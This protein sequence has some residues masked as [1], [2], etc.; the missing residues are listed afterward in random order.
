MS[1]ALMAA[2]VHVFRH[3]FITLFRHSHD[4]AV[5]PADIRVL[6]VLGPAQ[7]V[8]DADQGTV[9]LARDVV[10][11]LQRWS[12]SVKSCMGGGMGMGIVGGQ[13]QHRRQVSMTVRPQ[14]TTGRVH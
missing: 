4:A 13:K 14:R 2:D 3:E 9:S 5:H 7:A 1:S 12:G 10:G 6:E 8:Y 11:R